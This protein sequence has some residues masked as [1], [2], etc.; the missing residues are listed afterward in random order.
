MGRSTRGLSYASLWSKPLQ[1][2]SRR[3]NRS[4]S[5]IRG[6]RDRCLVF[7]VYY[8]VCSVALTLGLVPNPATLHHA[9]N[10]SFAPFPLIHD[11]SFKHYACLLPIL[12]Y[13]LAFVSSHLATSLVH[14]VGWISSFSP[15]RE[16]IQRI[17]SIGRNWMSLLVG[18]PRLASGGRSALLGGVFARAIHG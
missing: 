13:A 10:F 2:C 17:D 4:S 12:R 6:E 7:V 3:P 1:Q 18:S 16:R 15:P 5:R 9:S 8:E 11:T 14:I